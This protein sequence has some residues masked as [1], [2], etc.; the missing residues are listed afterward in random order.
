VGAGSRLPLLRRC[1]VFHTTDGAPRNL[2]DAIAAGFSTRED[3]SKARLR[4]AHAA[5]A[6]A[7]IEAGQVRQLGF[8]DQE[9]SYSLVAMTRS[10]ISHLGELQPELILT[11]PYE[12]GHPD[13][14]STAFAVH[15]ACRILRQ[16]SGYNPAIVEMAFYHRRGSRMVVGEFLSPVGG[17]S[18]KCMQILRLDQSAQRLK[19]QM[20]ACHASQAATLQSFDLEKE[21]FR[22]APEYD[23][24]QAPHETS[25]LYEW[26]DWGMTGERWR[27]L[28]RTAHAELGLQ[29]A[30]EI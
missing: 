19:Q 23:F 8:V 4:E 14:D 16:V 21:C 13:H 9:S 22:A 20:F 24:R 11:H 1:T 3:Y 7:G 5:L 18:A 17:D 2:H 15:A 29:V 27:D 6:L 26:Y 12:G 10:L 28:A 30:T 25:L